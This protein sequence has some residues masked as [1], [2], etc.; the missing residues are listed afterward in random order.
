MKIQSQWE[1]PAAT[2]LVEME[3]LIPAPAPRQAK[4][5][6]AEQQPPPPPSL[7][8]SCICSAILGALG[9]LSGGMLEVQGKREEVKNGLGW[10]QGVN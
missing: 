9:R 1:P 10:R 5:I 8:C 2:C 3:T 4:N 7:I 6:S